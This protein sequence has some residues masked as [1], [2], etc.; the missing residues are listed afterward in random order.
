[1]F[2]GRWQNERGSEM[3][4]YEDH[5]RISGE[6]L[7]K[8][9]DD[10]AKEKPFQLV[11]YCSE[12]TIGFVVAWDKTG[13]TTSWAGRYYKDEETGQEFIHTLWHLVR[14]ST[15]DDYNEEMPIWQSFLTNASLFKKVEALPYRAYA[16]VSTENSK[17]II[18]G[19]GVSGLA[20]AKAALEEGL[21]PVILDKSHSIGGLWQGKDGKIWEDM[22][23]NLSKWNCMFSDFPWKEGTPDF[24][25]GHSVHEYL[26]SYAEKFD[27]KSRILLGTEVININSI[28][29]QWII[30]LKNGKKITSPN[31]ICSTGV[32]AKPF[33]PKTPGLDGFLGK[34]F[35]SSQYRNAVSDAKKIAVIG[36]ALSGI[37]IAAHLAD[38]GKQV[39]IS[40]GHPPWIVPR[41]IKHKGKDVPLDLVL[42]QRTKSG[43]SNDIGHM[44]RYEKTA[45]F[46]EK[47]FKNPGVVHPEL[48]VPTKGIAPY[49]AISDTFLEHVAS[50]KIVPVASRLSAVDQSAIITDDGRRIEVDEIIFCTGYESDLSYLSESIQSKIE[51]SNDDKLIPFLADRTVYNP[52]VPGLY[53]VGLYR[54]PYF[55]VMELQ[56]RW[57]AM[58]I[59]GSLPVPSNESA[60]YAI[61]EERRL[62][63]IEPRPQFPHGNY[64]EFADSIAE[65]VKVV[66]KNYEDPDLNQ[67]IDD[68]PVVPSQF[69]LNGPHSNVRAAREIVLEAFSRV[70][71]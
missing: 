13:S 58:M 12:S 14:Q 37:E 31:V 2:N 27:L 19:A 45:E 22:R 69:R 65:A 46:F 53:F 9:G 28:D 47:N 42:Y 16:A 66:P 57:A 36:A 8:V 23:T 1:M 29:E 3:T 32:F 30:E 49:V 24:P 15:D 48:R 10:R 52:N 6:Y 56:A 4:L 71:S 67:A 54:G 64:V 33:I 18:I 39:V 51:Y 40:F 11:G 20:A 41:F 68:G 60:I 59:S 70:K 34:F 26:I 17:V 5:G 44:A 55:A 63:N 62:R 25:T 61:D 38:N 21:D 43:T 50:G 7:T 35:H